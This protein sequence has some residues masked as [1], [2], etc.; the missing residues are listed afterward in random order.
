M[1]EA[2]LWVASR[3]DLPSDVR[4]VTTR[5]ISLMS[6]QSPSSMHRDKVGSIQTVS[7]GFRVGRSA[8]VSPPI[9]QAGQHSQPT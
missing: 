1:P 9:R 2:E 7:A 6:T 5:P 4:F 8:V 3:R